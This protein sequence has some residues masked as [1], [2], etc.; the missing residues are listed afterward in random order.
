MSKTAQKITKTT[1]PAK[2]ATRSVKAKAAEPV[3]TPAPIVLKSKQAI[4]LDLLK[5]PQ[6]ATVEELM[7]ATGWQRHS[8]YGTLSGVVKKRLGL[9]VVSAHEARGRIYRITGVRA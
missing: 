6:G 2:T 1:T 4:I 5:H 8:V 3:P 9:N 7:Q